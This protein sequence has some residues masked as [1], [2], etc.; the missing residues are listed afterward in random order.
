MGVGEVVDEGAGEME[1]ARDGPG[2]GATEAGA[3]CPAWAS[4]CWRKR[5]STGTSVPRLRLMRKIMGADDDGGGGGWDM[6]A[7]VTVGEGRCQCRPGVG[8]WGGG[9]CLGA[10]AGAEPGRRP[11]RPRAALQCRRLCLRATAGWGGMVPGHVDRGGAHGRCAPRTFGSASGRAS[12]VESS[13]EHRA[14][15]GLR[16]RTSSAA[17]PLLPAVP[18]L[19]RKRPWRPH[20]PNMLL[21]CSAAKAAPKA[22]RLPHAVAPPISPSRAP[23]RSRP[24]PGWFA[25]ERAYIAWP[26]AL[27]LIGAFALA[28][29][30][31]ASLLDPYLD[32][33]PPIRSGV[34]PSPPAY[35]LVDSKFAREFGSIYV[36]DFHL[37]ATAGSLKLPPPCLAYQAQVLRPS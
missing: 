9:C 6:L 27:R 31:S 32:D 5:A 19:A 33:M 4:A 17:S 3:D 20:L 26:R 30:N 21:W 2:E 13:A 28:T 1:L 10:M 22:R 8:W 35:S 7:G 11:F 12:S 23:V 15:S 34:D 36:S 24:G 29:F 37:N 25:D 18:R 16:R 14:S